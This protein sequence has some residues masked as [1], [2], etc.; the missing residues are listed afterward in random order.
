M[1]IGEPAGKTWNVTR[2]GRPHVL[3]LS[4]TGLALIA[5]GS[6]A[7][8]T[9][10]WADLTAI[11]FPT[12]FSVHLTSASGIVTLGFKAGATQREFRE[13]L[14]DADVDGR[15]LPDRLVPP[16]RVQIGMDR[17]TTLPDF[18]G[19]VITKVHGVVTELS[20]NSGWTAATKGNNALDDA[21]FSLRNS[22]EQMSANAVV[23]LS[24]TTFAA[25][26]GIT[27]I[28]G[29]DAVGVLLLGTAVT[30][31]LADQVQST[32]TDT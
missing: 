11:T 3:S 24:A 25:N 8:T 22:A 9:Y 10:S 20:S 18:P 7:S 15:L 6:D 17:M 19:Y 26:G 14:R 5:D 32:S 29:G 28:V 13:A 12:S 31:A 1:D 4:D 27:N 23:G 30:I 21:M 2:D 16:R